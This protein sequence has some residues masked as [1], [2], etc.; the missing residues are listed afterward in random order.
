MRTT[1]FSCI[2]FSFL[3][4]NS[5]AQLNIDMVSHV[6]YSELHNAELNNVWGYVDETGIEYA[7]V[8]TTEGTSIL[9]LEDPSNPIEVFWEPGSASVWRELKTWGDHAY[10]T[11]EAEDGLLIID[12]SPLPQSNVLP[13]TYYFGPLGA[14]WS[15]AHSLFIDELG[16]AYIHGAN[17]GNGGVIMLDVHNDPM[18]PIEVG[19]FDNWYVHDSYARDNILYSG[20]ILD[21]FFSIVDVSDKANPVLINT[22]TTPFNFTHNTW[23]SDNSSILFTTDEVS[24]A[25]ITAYDIS[26]PM[27]ILETDRIRNTPEAGVI[28]HNVHVKDDYLITSYYSDGITIHD[29]SDPYNLILVGQYDTYPLQT[30]GFDGCWGVYPYLPSGLI[31]AS[32]ITEG[33]FVLQPDYY[34]AAYLKGNVT[35]EESGLPV[36]GVSVRITAHQQTDLSNVSGDYATG[37]VD[38]G[39]YTVSYSKIGY[40]PE[41]HIVTLINGQEVNFDVQLTPIPPFDFTVIVRDAQ[42]NAPISNAKIRL[43]ADLLDHDGVS[44]G[45]GVEDFVLYYQEEYRIYVA[46]WGYIA[47]CYDLEI[48]ETTGSI[49]VLLTRG[50]HD[51]FEFD[52][53]WLSSGNADKGLWERGVPNGTSSGS[54]PDIDAE[55]DCGKRA[56]VT[57]NDPS[58][59]PDFDD[60]DGGTAVLLSPQMNLTTYSDPHL[61]FA[62]WMYCVHGAPPNDSMR[63]IVS[64]GTSTAVVKV[65]GS[66]PNNDFQWR[67]YSVRLMDHI[68]ITSTMQVFFRL[69]DLDPDVNITEGGVDYFVITE[70]PIAAEDVLENNSVAVYPNPF[71]DLLR[72]NGAQDKDFTLMD[73][74]GR[75][76]LTDKIPSNALEYNLSGLASGFYVVRVGDELFKVL[77]D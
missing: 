65:I 41:E 3:I 33:L 46:K 47:N 14:E 5:N 63:V 10:I 73:L 32:D 40:Y 77:K 68:S 50:Y 70:E 69:A 37:I 49:T 26:D 55:F 21:G 19:V 58:P 22:K 16:Y 61:N 28:P 1:F 2:L 17:R 6:D 64:N 56:Y 38:G 44:N 7:I 66:D 71:T 11:T 4:L 43:E 35:D 45:I 23:L 59:N 13:T 15:S 74:N 18:N 75:V 34:R 12:L 30:S 60:V 42:T 36:S 52:L 53:G 54:A 20:H 48:N 25:Y 57:G 8:G 31:L 76:L 62:A 29:A 39:T 27:A 51:D 72:V 9:S 67:T 24:G